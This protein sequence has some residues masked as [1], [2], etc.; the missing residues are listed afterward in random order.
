[1]RDSAHL[2]LPTMKVIYLSI[3]LMSPLRKT[4][5]VEMVFNIELETFLNEE[6]V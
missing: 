6:K 4:A 2:S 1:M 3:C 5:K